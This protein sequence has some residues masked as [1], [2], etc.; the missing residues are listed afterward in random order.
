[1]ASA[2]KED[3]CLRIPMLFPSEPVSSLLGNNLDELV[4]WSYEKKWGNVEAIW[5]LGVFLIMRN[6]NVIDEVLQTYSP[7]V[8]FLT[9]VWKKNRQIWYVYL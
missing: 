8:Y 3:I 6:W 7:Q 5:D 1:M 4:K 9:N 2:H